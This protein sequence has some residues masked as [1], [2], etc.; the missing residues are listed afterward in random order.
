MGLKPF[1]IIFLNPWLK[2]GAIDGI[3]YIGIIFLDQQKEEL[4]F[5]FLK[6]KCSLE[7]YTIQNSLN[8][9][10]PISTQLFWNDSTLDE[11]DAI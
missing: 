4:F 1:M 7:T 9:C 11:I 5:P 2:P 8:Q 6:S 3:V 10:D